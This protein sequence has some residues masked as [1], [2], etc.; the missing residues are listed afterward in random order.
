MAK[1]GNY[2]S[3]K[4]KALKV[5]A[6]YYMIIGERSNGKTYSTLDY[7]IEKYFEDGSEMAI[8]RRLDEEIKGKRAQ[9]VFTNLVENGRIDYWSGG[10]W[11]DVYFY[12]GCWYF[13][14]W[15]DDGKTLIKDKRP[16]AYAFSISGG[17]H[18]KS[19]GGYSN[20][21]N[22]IFDEFLTRTGY[23]TDEFVLFMNLTST[24]IR[25]RND[26]KIFM[27]GNTVNK[28]S[29]YFVEMG[30]KHVK[31]MLPG[32]SQV[33]SIGQTKGKVYVEMSDSTAGGKKS[34]IYFAFDN[35]KLNMITKGS[36]EIDI[37]PHAPT[38]WK[39][40]EEVFKYFIEFDNELF[41]AKIIQTE[42]MYFTFINKKTTPLK[43]PD[44]DL[45][46]STRYDGRP[47]WRRSI[48][49]QQDDLGRKIW[50]FFQKEKVFY[51][52]NGVGDSIM[53]YL[54]W[55]GTI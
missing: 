22:I 1:K 10:L 20:V 33:Y 53:N 39:S 46:Y 49:H 13:C 30:L 23:L 24:I 40:K 36:W 2:Y 3:L 19:A 37:Y 35:P 32:D 4:R 9:R 21:R 44:E 45:I 34:D 6:Q 14:R 31:N 38:K 26:V 50:D 52:D 5:D 54:N 18:D 29:P 17:M 28:Y 11:N 43:K 27:L 16:F 25:D 48:M 7:G 41:E 42:D 51:S 47:N 12:S 15:E 8:V 55:C